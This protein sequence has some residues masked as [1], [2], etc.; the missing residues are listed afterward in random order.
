MSLGSMLPGLFTV[1]AVS[2]LH[3]LSGDQQLILHQ[4]QHDTQASGGRELS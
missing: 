4:P 3:H 2:H 1:V